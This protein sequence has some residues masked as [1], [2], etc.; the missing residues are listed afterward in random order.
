MKEEHL[1]DGGGHSFL[2]ES[3][4]MAIFREALEFFNARSIEF[5]TKIVDC[6]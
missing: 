5:E 3:E 2:I 6:N 1:S 4:T